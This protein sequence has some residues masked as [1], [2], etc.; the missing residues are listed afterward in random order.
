MVSQSTQ[1]F[2]A[3][4]YCKNV[5]SQGVDRCFVATQLVAAQAMQHGL[6]ALHLAC[7]GLPIRPAFNAPTRSKTEIRQQ[8]GMD[9]NS[10][11]VMLIG[12][13]EGMG[14]L[15]TTADALSQTLGQIFLTK[16]GIGN[17][18][19]ICCIGFGSLFKGL[20]HPTKLLLFVAAMKNSRSLY[21]R[22]H[23]L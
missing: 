2:F 4:I 17:E 12:G 8:L 9:T 13:G 14:K 1:F 6:S 19:F 18:Q 22:N 10:S 15:E 23:G 7:Y 3:F 5:V 21:P 20:L 16:Y 11:T